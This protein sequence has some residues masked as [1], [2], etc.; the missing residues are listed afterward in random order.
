MAKGLAAEGRCG[1]AFQP[2]QLGRLGLLRSVLACVCGVTRSNVWS[3]SFICGT[4]LIDSRFWF[5]CLRVCLI[6]LFACVFVYSCHLQIIMHARTIKYITHACV[7]NKLFTN[8]Y[9]CNIYGCISQIHIQ[10]H[11]Q[12]HIYAYTYI[13][14]ACTHTHM[15]KHV[16]ILIQQEIL[17]IQALAII[18]RVTHVNESWPTHKWVMSHMCYQR[19]GRRRAPRVG[20]P[21][22]TTGSSWTASLRACLRVWHNSFICVISRIHACMTWLNDS[23]LSYPCLVLAGIF[24]YCVWNITYT[25]THTRKTCVPMYTLAHT[26]TRIYHTLSRAYTCNLYA[27][28]YQYTCTHI[29][30]HA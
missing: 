15:Y 30:M 13:K 24:V 25:H 21:T 1:L 28:K 22:P 16:H 29:C 5:F 18:N 6:S 8:L 7:Y 23:P 17:Q 27:C 12:I 14:H 10:V 2:R 4:W 19:S 9:A 26:I 11:I 20:L 3:D